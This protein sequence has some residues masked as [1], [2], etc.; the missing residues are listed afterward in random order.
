MENSL[1]VLKKSSVVSKLIFASVGFSILVK[2]MNRLALLP[3][4]IVDLIV[5]RL[6]S[7]AIMKVC[8]A[9]RTSHRLAMIYKNMFE[10]YFPILAQSRLP[11]T[12]ST[13]KSLVCEKGFLPYRYEKWNQ[14]Q[15]QVKPG[16]H[17]TECYFHNG[18]IYCFFSQKVAKMLYAQTHLMTM[19]GAQFH[20]LNLQP[21][22]PHL[23]V[24][25]P[26]TTCFY[27]NKLFKFMV[28]GSDVE[29]HVFE[30][31]MWTLT[32]KQSLG[33]SMTLLFTRLENDQA[34]FIGFHR[35]KV[36]VYMY[37]FENV[38]F[39]Q[40]KSEASPLSVNVAMRKYLVHGD[41]VVVAETLTSNSGVFITVLDIKSLQ[42]TRQNF[43]LILG[44][45][46]KYFAFL[47]VGDF[48]F[49]L[50]YVNRHVRCFYIQGK[51]IIDRGL[52]CGFRGI[53]LPF[54]FPGGMAQVCLDKKFLYTEVLR[55]F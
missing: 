10:S 35:E 18:V 40:L 13:M 12:N 34:R 31:F 3:E 36:H 26:S 33:E 41:S 51:S 23:T 2:D 30:N 43:H 53:S 38:R 24:V 8:K 32:L 29:V 42:Y 7:L 20:E 45:H 46:I 50:N 17:T 52:I 11:I 27:Q 49:I 21:I 6:S 28:L 4:P 16:W 5:S 47:S 25:C 39:T 37:D 54:A 55:M 1:T 14:G 22:R 9:L 48:V 44:S 19:T 15:V